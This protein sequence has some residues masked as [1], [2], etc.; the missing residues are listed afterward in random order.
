MNGL[1]KITE[2]IDAD[3]KAEAGRIL[4]DAQAKA[5]AIAAEWAE[6]ARRETDDILARGKKNAAERQERLASVARLEGRKKLLGA[7]QEMLGK[8]FDRAL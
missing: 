3:A 8:A 5:D 4:A 6:K 7:K 2:R 1:D